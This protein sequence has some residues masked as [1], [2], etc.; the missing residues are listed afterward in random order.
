MVGQN[1]SGSLLYWII[2]IQQYLGNR[3]LPDLYLL[4]VVEDVQDT[5]K[6]TQ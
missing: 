4:D 5:F 1:S 6:R 3:I 2:P